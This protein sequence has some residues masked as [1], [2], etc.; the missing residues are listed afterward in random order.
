[1]VLDL[2][3]VAFMDLAGLRTVLRLLE[4]AR[5]NGWDLGI[6]ATLSPSVVKLARL[7]D[8]LSALPLIQDDLASHGV[9]RIA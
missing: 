2:S 1:M 7:T 6:A 4:A 9:A 5:G 3:G 8:M